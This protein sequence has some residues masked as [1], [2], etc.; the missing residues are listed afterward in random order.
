[1]TTIKKES[2]THDILRLA[3]MFNKPIGVEEV[4]TVYGYVDRPSKVQRSFEILYRYG[5]VDI[6]EPGRFI[7]TPMGIDSVF[8]MANQSKRLYDE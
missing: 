7:I 6:S 1:M 4:L 3:K 8:K 2:L 5:L